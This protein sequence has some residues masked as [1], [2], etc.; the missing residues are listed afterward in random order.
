MRKKGIGRAAGTVGGA[1]FLS[2][3]FGLT[4][5]LLFAALLGAGFFADAYVIA[6]RIPNLLRDLFAE[7]AFSNAFVPTFTDYR[8][9]R[10]RE[11]AW[12]LGNLVLGVLLLVVGLLTLLGIFLSPEIVSLIA[13]GFGEIPG[14][15]ELTVLLTRIMFPFLPAI[16]M[17]SLFMGMLNSHEEF[18]APAFA[19]VLFNVVSILFGLS[20]WFMGAG[21][22]VAVVGWSIGTLCGGLAQA[23]IQL[24]KLS[25]LGWKIRPRLKGW[26]SEPG[27]KQIGLLMLPAVIGLS[28]TQINILVNTILASLLEQGAPSWLNYAFRLMQLPIGVF[29]VAVAVVTLSKVSQA[30]AEGSDED[31]RSHLAESLGLVFVLTIPCAVGLWIL[32]EPIIRLIYERGAFLS[33]DTSATAQAL[34]H[35]AIGLPAYAAVKVLAPA[36]YARK[37]ARAPMFASIAAVIVN[38]VF[39][40][41]V[42]RTMGFKGLALG[43][44]LAMMVNLGLLTFW[45][46]T[47]QVGLPLWK[48]SKRVFMIG[49]S[50]VPMAWVALEGHGYLSGQVPGFFGYLLDTLV[51]IVLAALVYFAG[52]SFLRV[53]EAKLVREAFL[54]IARKVIGR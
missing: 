34:T 50:C 37:N 17:A 6:F 32:G 40:L 48:L 49:L 52:I 16:A 30:A 53:P 27:L 54:K 7:G 47:G 36:F 11:Q 23:A 45:F 46:Q 2:R 31:F 25:Q 39:N 51:P 22:K 35:Y 33:T 18:T 1:T 26:K 42:Y 41:A 43:T 8:L 19:P 29:G 4:R 15:H 28:A 5:D 44:S 24:P 12:A 20:L 13:P 21:G 38:I 14:K 10:S 3:I 9:N